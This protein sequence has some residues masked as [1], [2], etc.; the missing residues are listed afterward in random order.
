MYFLSFA[1]PLRTIPPR[2]FLFYSPH[3]VKILIKTIDI[4]THY[5][6]QLIGGYF[7]VGASLTSKKPRLV[8]VVG[9][10]GENNHYRY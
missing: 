7:L 6:V 8:S 3:R 5:N 2:G 9:K 4:H 10:I 1:S